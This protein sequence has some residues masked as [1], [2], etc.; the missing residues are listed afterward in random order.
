[1]NYNLG[2]KFEPFALAYDSVLIVHDSLVIINPRI[3]R[4][5]FRRKSHRVIPIQLFM[6]VKLA[7]RS[8]S[9]SD[10][11][12][13]HSQLPVDLKLFSVCPVHQVDASR[14]H[15]N[16]MQDENG[17]HTVVNSISIIR[18]VVCSHST[19]HSTTANGTFEYAL[20]LPENSISVSA[21]GTSDLS[22]TAQREISREEM[23]QI[24]GEV[25]SRIEQF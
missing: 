1:M 9:R 8:L 21:L 11:P 17:I 14:P 20:C 19:L 2:V 15:T 5:A 4:K 12:R 16:D 13:K 6:N 22:G 18:L 24:R 10:Q 25:L 3:I 23:H 7:K